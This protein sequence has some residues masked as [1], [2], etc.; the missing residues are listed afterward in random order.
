M[1]R[2]AM[3]P[4][5]GRH[6]NQHPYL[7]DSKGRAN[8]LDVA[9]LIAHRPS[10]SPGRG[11]TEARLIPRRKPGSQLLLCNRSMPRRAGY[12]LRTEDGLTAPRRCRSMLAPE[13]AALPSQAADGLA[14]HHG[15]RFKQFDCIRSTMAE[16]ISLLITRYHHQN[17]EDVFDLPGFVPVQ[18]GRVV[19]WVRANRLQTSCESSSLP[20]L[21]ISS[22]TSAYVE[23]RCSSPISPALCLHQVRGEAV[24][25]FA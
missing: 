10:S 5:S 2:C 16:I 12:A 11:G 18:T 20:W 7:I 3:P 6:S 22:M 21:R 1:G 4:P 25:N 14:R 24:A 13:A 19:L 9:S 8:C 15:D 23:R 17:D